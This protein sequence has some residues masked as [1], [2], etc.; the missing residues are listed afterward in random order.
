MK[1]PSRIAPAFLINRLEIVCGRRGAVWKIN[2]DTLI[3]KG[4][5]FSSSTG[6]F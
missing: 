6:S 5:L 3:D 4:W 2:L 1:F